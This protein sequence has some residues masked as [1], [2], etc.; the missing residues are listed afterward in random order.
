MMN[1]KGQLAFIVLLVIIGM[2]VLIYS[3]ATD[4]FRLETG[5]GQK[6]SD[7]LKSYS[8]LEGLRIYVAEAAK[9]SAYSALGPLPATDCFAGVDKDEFIPGVEDGMQQFTSATLDTTL[10]LPHY[11]FDAEIN[12]NKILLTGIAGQVQGLQEVTQRLLNPTGMLMVINNA[13]KATSYV[14]GNFAIALS[15]DNYKKFNLFGVY[16]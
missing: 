2:T 8:D 14:G 12:S 7:L 1:K 5:I 16:Q 4:N 3:K 6:Q 9:Y 15:C 13:S 11:R 10:K